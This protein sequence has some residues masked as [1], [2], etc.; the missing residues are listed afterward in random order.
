MISKLIKY[1]QEP[2]PYLYRNTQRLLLFLG[3]ISAL[4]FFF[5]YTFEPFEVNVAE[6]KMDYFWIS[7][8]HAFLPF[9]I[10]F[11]YFTI[12]NWSL[13]DDSR[14][15]LG[16]E[17]FHLSILLLCIGITD[18]LIRDVIYDNPN[19][20]SLRY[21]F[22]EIR[23]TFLVGTL[24]LIIVLPLN[25][26]RLIYKSTKS[27][28]RLKLQA[29]NKS[30]KQQLVNIASFT[31]N[32]QF[33]IAQFLFAKVESNYTEIYIYNDSEVKKILLRIT[34]KELETQLQAFPNIYKTHRSYLV[35]L[36]KITAC[37]GNAQ[38]YQLSLE[39]YSG[40]VPVSRS[41]I[42]AFNAYFSKMT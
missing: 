29:P 20:W 3:I 11:V 36:Q 18:F 14:W 25:L 41:N 4:S 15:T 34:L 40:T 42:T 10:A 9:P 2:Y 32:Y 21:F 8:I 26:E 38:G 12:V 6:H 7:F 30:I 13:K 28:K 33:D 19:N 37:T 17:I 27:L 1:L 39:D 5:S 31:E 16:K 24:L 22:E 23:N 35:N